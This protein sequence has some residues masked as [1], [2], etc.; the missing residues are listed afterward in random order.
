MVSKFADDGKIGSVVDSKK[1][2]LRVQR[3]LDQMSK[4]AEDWQME[5]NLDKCE[6]LHFEKANQG[7]TYTLNVK[8]LGSVA[9]HLVVEVH[10][11]LKEE[12]QVEWVV[13]KAFG[14]LAFI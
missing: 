10:R 7:R 4:W 8:V 12:P 13:K 9:K 2:Y 1:G 14:T 3:D 6:V 5:F 11:S